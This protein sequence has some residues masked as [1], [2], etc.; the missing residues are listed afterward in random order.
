MTS[1]T[2]HV[3]VGNGDRL[4]C[5]NYCPNVP[6]YFSSTK[7]L[8][9]LYILPI[10]GTDVVL[11]IQW[12]KTLGPIVTDYASLIMQL[13]WNGSPV[14]LK[15]IQDP[16]IS[17]ISSNQLKCMHATNAISEYYHLQVEN[18]SP[19]LSPD[20]TLVPSTV[21]PILL[22]FSS[23]FQ[24]T[25]HLPPVRAISHKIE[26][27]PNSS[28]VNVRPYR[29]P[30]LQK[31]E[32]ERLIKDMLSSGLIRPSTSSF[33]SPVLLVK[34]KDG[35]WR[36]CVNYRA[37]NNVTIKDRFPILTIDEL[38]D[39]LHGSKF[40]SKLDLRSGYHQI[41]MDD[42]D[43]HKTAFRTHEGHYEFVVLPFGLSNAPATF[44]ATMHHILR[45]YLRK[46][47]IVFFDDILIYSPTMESHLQQLVLVFQS[48]A[49]ASFY[50]KFSKCLFLQQSVEY[51]GH[52][53]SA[54]GVEPDPSKIEGC[55]IGLFLLISNSHVGFWVL[56]A[57]ID[58]LLRI[59]LLSPL[60]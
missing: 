40:F 19:L 14:H 11:G 49:E 4:S 20:F 32:I 47:A 44:Q 51:L 39:E 17:E 56:P 52:I 7:F 37:L 13:N 53:I 3:L 12:L 46:F 50:L 23:L 54:H 5:S 48:L 43:I 10:S 28:P 2:F 22:Q 1:P 16:N 6:V 58:V 29:Y 27:L 59:T 31:N 24:D 41:R 55:F 38:L 25:Q 34:K 21:Q 35:S 36:F 8:T 60:N 18:S 57:F 9:D 45:P 26:L 30:H 42:T 33:S 15:G